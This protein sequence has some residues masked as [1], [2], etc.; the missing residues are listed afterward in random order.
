[1]LYMSDEPFDGKNDFT[2]E[3]L[4]EIIDRGKKLGKKI[5]VHA[6]HSNEGLRR[7]LKFDIDTL[8]HPFYRHF[9]VDEDIIKGYADNGVIAA[10][11]LRVMVAGPEHTMN[12]H[13]FNSTDYI[14][15][16][17]PEDYRLLMRY[18]DK[19]LHI[20][21]NPG[22]KGISIYDKR[23]SESDMFGQLGPSF[24]EQMK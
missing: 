14:M 23:G 20:K 17:T 3:Q 18:R 9:L 19:M 12:P 15:S 7:F 8:E 22:E 4:Q 10:S 16:S 5:D 21:R 13:R 11:L 2:D 6:Q 24:E 1:K